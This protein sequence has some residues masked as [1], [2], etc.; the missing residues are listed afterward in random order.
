VPDDKPVS[1][2]RHL[3]EIRDEVKREIAGMS[4]EEQQRWR[5]PQRAMRMKRPFG[6]ESGTQ[7]GKAT[8]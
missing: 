1:Y 7:R 3:P 4:F 6:P 5:K 2:V 8:E